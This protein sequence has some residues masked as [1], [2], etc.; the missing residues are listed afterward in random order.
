MATMFEKLASKNKK[1]PGF[2]AKT[3]ASHPQ[4]VERL[5]ASQILVARFPEREEYVLSTS[6]F[7]R[8]KGR[9]MRL[10]NAKASTAGDIGGG[11]DGPRRPTLKRRSPA[12]DATPGTGDGK[13]EKPAPPTMKRP[14]TPPAATDKP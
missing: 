10:S 1:K 4:S 3:F 13:E 9:L 6:E 14:D 11:E 2:L 5:Q 7:Q 12:P 8:V